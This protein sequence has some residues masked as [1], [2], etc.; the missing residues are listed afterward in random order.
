[1]SPLIVFSLAVRVCGPINEGCHWEN[2]ADY[3]SEPVC[4]AAGGVMQLYPRVFGY[5][6]TVQTRE[7]Q[8]RTGVGNPF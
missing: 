6:C 7:Y 3:T 4:R 1:M 5:K 2:I 8:Y